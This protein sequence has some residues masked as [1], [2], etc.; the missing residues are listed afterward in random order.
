MLEIRERSLSFF[1]RERDDK[2]S[3]FVSPGFS[4]KGELPT[5]ALKTE[6]YVKKRG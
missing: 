4:F 1:H 3:Y 6:E 2:H 5:T